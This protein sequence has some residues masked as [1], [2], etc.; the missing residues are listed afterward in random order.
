MADRVAV[1]DGISQRVISSRMEFKRHGATA[2]VGDQ[3]SC[4][5]AGRDFACFI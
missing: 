4:V 5:I 3:M 1:D 2:G